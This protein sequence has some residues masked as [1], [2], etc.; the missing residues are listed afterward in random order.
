MHRWITVLVL[1]IALVSAKILADATQSKNQHPGTIVDAYTHKGVSASAYAYGSETESGGSGCPTYSD[2]LDTQKSSSTTGSFTFHIDRGKSGYL[3]A[4]CE[5]GFAPR[6][7]TA[8][9][10]SGDGTRVQP[11]PITLFPNSPSAGIPVQIATVAIRTDLSRL[12]SDF[13]YY[14]RSNPTAFAEGASKFS[15]RDQNILKDLMSYD[16]P[17]TDGEDWFDRRKIDSPAMAFVA[18]ATDLNAARSNFIYYVQADQK[19]YSDA[20]SESF[21]KEKQTIEA[22]RKRPEPWRR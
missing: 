18:I 10:N 2:L 6:T 7:E 22:I 8:N 4:Y 12:H 15:Q 5:A 14:S 3:A 11:D 13:T 1:P 16:V 21:P 9:D 20:L 19:A 17:A